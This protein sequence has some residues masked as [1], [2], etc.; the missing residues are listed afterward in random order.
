MSSRGGGITKKKAKIKCE[1]KE[2]KGVRGIVNGIF[3]ITLWQE[4]S[5]KF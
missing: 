2:N 4:V 3:C 1:D 5:L